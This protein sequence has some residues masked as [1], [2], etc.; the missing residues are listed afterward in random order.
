MRLLIVEDDQQLSEALS[1]LLRQSGYEVDA[2][3]DGRTALNALLASDYDLAVIDLMLPGMNGVAL[4]RSLRKQNRGLPILIITARDSIEDRVGGLD[5][6]AD[7]YLVKPFEMPE[8][9]ARIRALLRRQRADR[10][11]EIRVGSLTMVPGQPRVS[12]GG[13]NV[14]LPASELALLETLATRLGRVVSKQ[15]IAERLSRGGNPP[16]DTA[17]EVCVHRLR[18]RL[19][20]FGLKVRTLRGF[21]YLLESGTYLESGTHA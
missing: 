8:L 6:G 3:A 21:G 2:H 20:P 13:T 18:R 17:I 16:S 10:D 11:S 1:A 14:D 4:V 7:D 9:E 15:T 19:G 5:A 12:L